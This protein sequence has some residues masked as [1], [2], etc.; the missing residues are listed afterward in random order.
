M[1]WSKIYQ[2]KASISHTVK[3]EGF[4]LNSIFVES[5]IGIERSLNETVSLM[6]SERNGCQNKRFSLFLSTS[7]VVW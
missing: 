2:A 7:M 1:K 5:A 4:V 3:I 6:P